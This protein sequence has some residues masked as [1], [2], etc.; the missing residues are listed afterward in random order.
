M[1]L[2]IENI[3]CAGCAKGVTASIHSVDPSA[4]VQVDVANKLADIQT[5]LTFEQVSETL[6]EDGFPP[7]KKD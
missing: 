3:S 7:V 2:Y 4:T 5:T 6:S 1:K